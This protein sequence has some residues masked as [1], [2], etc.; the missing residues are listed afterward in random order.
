MKS[1]PERR[2]PKTFAYKKRIIYS[3]VI[4][5]A[6]LLFVMGLKIFSADTQDRV[7]SQKPVRLASARVEKQPDTGGD[8]WDGPILYHQADS[9]PIDFILVEKATQQLHLYRYDGRYRQIKSYMCGTGEK[10]GK[11]KRENDEKTPEGIYFNVK[12]YRDSKVTIF[13]DRAFGLNYPDTFDVLDGNRGSGIFIHGSNKTV[14]PFSTNGCVALNNQDLADLDKRIQ[15]KK[16][17]VIIGH[18]LPY[19]FTSAVKDVSKLIPLFKKAMIPQSYAHLKT[20]FRALTVLGFKKRVVA[21]GEVRIKEAKNLQGFSR[22]YLGRPDKNLLVLLKR[23]WDEKKLV[24][25]R[26]KAKP[27]PTAKDTARIA[28][29]VASWRKAWEGKKLKAY[30]SHYHPAFK[31]S[32]KDLAAWK[33]YKAR[34][35][36]Q[37]R[38]ISVKVSGL[39]VKVKNKKAYAY[40]KQRYRTDTFKSSRY[41]R[42]EF[43]KKGAFWKIYRERSYRWKQADWPT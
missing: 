37:Y 9:E 22:L 13:G 1:R 24:V 20:D 10:R 16:T 6:V 30:I 31:S 41:K 40:F 36:K 25:A 34:L 15:F 42:L 29:V 12:A 26:A 8:L 7:Q 43:R 28:S 38:R 18:H 17:P 2:N 14:T 19:R 35:N 4:S 32:G 3:I 11:K 21:V 5:L 33:R 27:R 39:K 23:D